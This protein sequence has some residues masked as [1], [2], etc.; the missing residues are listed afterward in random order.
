MILRGP[1][2]GGTY[3]GRAAVWPP[4]FALSRDPAVVTSTE[5][6]RMK[7]DIFGMLREEALTAQRQEVMR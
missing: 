5:F 2:G 7:S 1:E 6:V 3:V 4:Q